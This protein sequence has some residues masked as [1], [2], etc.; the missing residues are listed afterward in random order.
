[1]LRSVRKLSEYTVLATDG[2]M[3]H[4]SEF[5]FDDE[6]W[7]VRHLVVDVSAW[8]P[9]RRRVLISPGVLGQSD[10]KSKQFPVNLSRDQ[11]KNS[12]SVDLNRP[13]S[14]QIEQA[15]LNY[16]ALPLYWSRPEGI[17]VTPE[18]IGELPDPAVLEE[19]AREYGGDLH[20]RSTREVMDYAVQA[21]DGDVGY[22]ADFILEDDSWII[23]YLV[24]HVQEQLPGKQVLISP[25][26]IEQVSWADSKASVNLL[27]RTIFDSPGYDPGVPLNRD[28]EQ[29][30]YK[31]YKQ[32]EYWVG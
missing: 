15:L 16:Y 7:T 29:K 17:P 1:M 3:G 14:R 31:H 21:K 32:S 9:E 25:A 4:V 30:L 10:W 11:V 5:Y 13:V 8:L 20:L 2:E 26:W 6:S 24:I 27:Q 12:P 22:V 18:T 19:K 23:R 28:Y